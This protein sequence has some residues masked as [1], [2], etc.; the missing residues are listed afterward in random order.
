MGGRELR[1]RNP[2]RSAG[3]LRLGESDKRARLGGERSGS[4]LD[5]WIRATSAIAFHFCALRHGPIGR[6]GR[7]M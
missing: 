6:P 1:G 3:D 7:R 2:R 5:F 4:H